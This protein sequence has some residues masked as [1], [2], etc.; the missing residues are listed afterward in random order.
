MSDMHMKALHEQNK[1]NP[2]LNFII[3]ILRN[4]TNIYGYQLFLRDV[5]ERAEEQCLD[6]HMVMSLSLLL[7]AATL[8][9]FSRD[10]VLS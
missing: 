1:V 2:E 5:E 9:L 3:I 10:K 4:I 6:S 7:H 8:L